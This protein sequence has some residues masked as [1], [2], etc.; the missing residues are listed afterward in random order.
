MNRSFI[1]A[2]YAA[3]FLVISCGERDVN[4]DKNTGGASGNSYDTELAEEL[5]ADD[6][7]MRQYVIAFLKEGP[8][9][10]QDSTRA[11]ELQRAHLDNI[12]R[13]AEEGKLVL[14]GPFMDQQEVRG[15]FVFDVRT[16]EE[17]RQLT[18]SDPAIEAGRLEVDLRPWYG[19]AALMQVNNIHSKIS[20]INP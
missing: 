20:K 1:F 5:G 12:R 15:I 14:A 3:L 17:A 11:A 7:G 10:G 19:S 6:Y 16:V 2:L 13:L 8:N 4:T 18:E 9:R